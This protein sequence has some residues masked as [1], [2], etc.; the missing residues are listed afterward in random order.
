[1]PSDSVVV[2]PVFFANLCLALLIGCI[3]LESLQT[4]TLQAVQT[5]TAY[6]ADQLPVFYARLNRLGSTL[7]GLDNHVMAATGADPWGPR[8]AA[9]IEA[10]G[11]GV[12]RLNEAFAR[13][14]DALAANYSMG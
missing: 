12:A 5:H 11:Q 3:V 7:E 10:L 8:N 14:V 6:T 2:W 1:M 13:L 4:P 9:G